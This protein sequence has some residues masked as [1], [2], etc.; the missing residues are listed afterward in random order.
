[1]SVFKARKKRATTKTPP[2]SS[3]QKTALE[4]GL[5]TIYLDAKGRLPDLG[6]LDKTPS[7]TGILIGCVVMACIGSALLAWVGF[8]LVHRQSNI[9]VSPITLTLNGP[10]QV[11]LG[12]EQSY[13][14]VWKNTGTDVV[15][16][17]DIRVNLPADFTLTSLDP[18]PSSANVRLWH[19]NNL[20]PNSAGHIRVKGYFV[21]SLGGQTAIQTLTTY[22]LEDNQYTS[23]QT[24]LKTI[25]YT[26]TVLAGNL[27]FP[28]RVLA[29][30][31]VPIRYVIANLGKQP[32]TNLMARVTLPVGFI[33]N[34]VATS[35]QMDLVNRTLTFP[36]GVLAPN[37][38][39]TANVPGIFASGMSGDAVFIGETGRM[40]IDGGFLPAAHSESRLAIAPGDVVF[41]LV[42]NGTD[43]GR[44]IT[45]GEPLRAA[46]EYQN[47]SGQSLK[48]I[49]ITLAFESLVNGKS[50][51][52]TSLLNWNQLSDASQ[53][54]SSTKTRL[55]V[56][57][58]NK[59]NTPLFAELPS[60]AKGRIEVSLPTLATSTGTKDA[61]IRVSARV[62]AQ[63]PGENQARELSSQPITLTYRSDAKVSVE[64]RYYS[65]EG[66]PMGTGPLPP[67]VGTSTSYRV[68]WRVRKSLHDLADA[69]VS[70]V[71]PKI[72]SWK[73]K[74]DAQLG[75]IVYDEVS[76]TVTWTLGRVPEGSQE[77][78][79][80]FDIS[81]T[82]EA[83]DIGR[84]AS[85]L[86]ETS[87]QAQDAHIKETLAQTLPALNT[88]LST[89]EGAR[90]KGVVRKD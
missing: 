81:L 71:L 61:L 76:R 25:V 16:N 5:N 43:T 4:E 9:R 67:V 57:H 41:H 46:F 28:T 82:P 47:V 60:Q 20:Q 33:T 13:D 2:S 63:V 73:G 75:D 17:V 42:A 32:M 21:G 35:V 56:I 70:V 26:G 3:D 87:F 80:W 53:G 44:S 50:T 11:L 77:V 66:V 22:P 69:K 7:R 36:I 30:E 74:I 24:S 72:V 38:F 14:L 78:E 59:G 79:G 37:A 39:Y 65:E 6:T 1:M 88:D 12:E 90:G 29:G 86:G 83:L 15:K 85:L 52:G 64:A 8:S 10:E 45:A 19:L 55:Q 58:Y 18:A 40:S 49:S 23:E 68:F 51:T 54:T 62:Y 89:D 84:F 48:D 31:S 27:L 34:A